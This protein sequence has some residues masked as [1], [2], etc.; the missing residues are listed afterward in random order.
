[1]NG[2]TEIRVGNGPDNVLDYEGIT[3]LLAE[4]EAAIARGKPILFQGATEGRYFCSGFDL[5]TLALLPEKE[6][7]RAFA[8]FLRLGRV[9]F[10]APVPVA[11]LAKGHAIGIGA[12]LLLAADQALIAARAKLRFPET[13][14]GL[15]LFADMAGMI[16]HRS[17]GRLA[18]R[19]LMQAE[20]LNRYAGGHLWAGRQSSR[21]FPRPPRRPFYRYWPF[22]IGL[23]SSKA[24][25]SCGCVACSNRASARFFLRA[26]GDISRGGHV[27]I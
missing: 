13:M 25:M 6:L 17:T 1:M 5:A 22:E 7:R 18:E 23:G 8:D 19:M 16:G 26:L 2:V 27:L 15:G 24:S 3:E 14:L 10:T 21:R 4:V 12:T 20:P 11:V 9:V